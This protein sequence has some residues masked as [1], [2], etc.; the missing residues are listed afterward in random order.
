MSCIL[1]F[2]SS[3]ATGSLTDVNLSIDILPLGDNEEIDG[4]IKEILADNQD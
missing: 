4:N 1:T 3:E 2:D